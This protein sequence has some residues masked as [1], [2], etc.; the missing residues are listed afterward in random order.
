MDFDIKGKIEELV[1]K[2]GG[3][4]KL[5][6]KFTKDPV[7]AVRSLLGSVDLSSEQLESLAAGVKAK[8]NLDQ[9]GDILGKLGGLLGK[10]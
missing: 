2:I 4:K 5:L 9:A 8:L 1:K 7:G 10:K 6:E 3:D